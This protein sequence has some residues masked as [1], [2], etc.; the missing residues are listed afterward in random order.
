[1]AKRPVL[2]VKKEPKGIVALKQAERL[3]KMGVRNELKPT[4]WGCILRMYG[5][6]CLAC[7]ST[8]D[9]TMDHVKALIN[10]G[11][12]HPSNIQPLCRTCNSSKGRK[13]IDYRVKH[14]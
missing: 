1:M 5:K 3:R 12:H 10:G 9:I 8:K 11:R 2:R 14:A 7:G 6:R 4:D 13:T